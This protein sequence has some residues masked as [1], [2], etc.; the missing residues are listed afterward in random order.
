MTWPQYV[1]LAW[2]L[3]SAVVTVRNEVRNRQQSSGMAT[4]GIFLG[5]GILAGLAAVLHA[6]GFW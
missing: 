4:F 2:F 1:M 6:G 3:F 5:I